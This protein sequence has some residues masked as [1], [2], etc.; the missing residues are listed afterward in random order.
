MG[1]KIFHIALAVFALMLGLLIWRLDIPNWA[2]LDIEKLTDIPR[3]TQVFDIHGNVAGRL[4]GPEKRSP[5]AIESVPDFVKNAFIAAE[6]LRFYRHHGI[7]V[8]RMFGAL[9][10]NIKTLS[11][12]QGASTITQQLIKLT[13]LTSTKSL[14]RKAQEIHLALQLERQMDKD[15]ILECYLNVAYFGRGA[16]GI[17]AAAQSYF[18]KSVGDLTVSEIAL[19]AGIVKAP[20][21]Y[22]P[23]LNYELSLKRR[24]GILNTMLENGFITATTHAEALNDRPTI[25]ED[26]TPATNYGWYMDAVLSEAE[27]ILNL[28]AEEIFSGGFRIYTGL[29]P[30]MQNAAD[31]L[32]SDSANFPADASDETPVQ[33]AFI[34]MEPESGMVLAMIGG[35]SY[36]LRRGFN[37]AIQM[38]RQPGSTFKP[39]AAYAAAID[40]YGFCPTSTVEDRPRDFDGYA[41]GNAGGATYGTVTLRQ[42]LSKSLNIATVDLADLIGIPALRTYAEKFGIHLSD[43][44]Q[45]L[46]LALGMLTDGL[47]P[48]S[49]ASAYCALANGGQQVACHFIQRIESADG[50]VKYRFQPTTARAIKDSTAY[51]LTHML[52]TAAQSGSARALN[53][54]SFP[55]AGKTGTLENPAGGNRD[56]WTVAYTPDIAIASW[57]GFDN[58]SK[59]HALSSSEGGSGYPARLCAAFLNKV[60]PLL[61]QRD[62]VRPESV[63]AVMIDGL[64]LEL[65]THVLLA[66][67]N[68]PAE[69]TVEE[70]FHPSALPS[71]FSNYWDAP[72]AVTDLRLLSGD[73]ETPLMCFTARSNLCDYVIYRKSEGNVEEIAVLTEES[74]TLIQYSDTAH[75]LRYPAVYTVIPRNRYLF[76]TGQLLTGPE[77]SPVQYAPGSF[78]NRIMGIG[79]SKETPMPTDMHSD[80]FYSPQG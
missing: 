42:A 71:R 32:F 5:V 29:Y 72:E 78:L 77:S 79:A 76:K 52:K 2:K 27:S 10:Q 58:P 62:F 11:Y 36:D 37:R 61:S 18:G 39:L 55:V 47:S 53:T 41:P 14:S 13:H 80:T 23:H 7:D 75:D 63:K 24:N 34:A 65:D 15:T 67:E 60:A 25:I 31:E 21:S 69:Y 40:A 64:A 9:F 50:Q 44:D 19:L 43:Q 48:A 68:T 3:S 59:I 20:S 8:Y 12:A 35:R 49:L 73:G 51:M 45:N 17:A 26:T 46:S 70:L 30:D 57:M 56:I 4:S 6:D 22:A 66:S 1:R 38:Q 16:Y 74:G 54:V 33:S 28:S